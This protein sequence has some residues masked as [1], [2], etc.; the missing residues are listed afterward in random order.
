MQW[1]ANDKM[2][3]PKLDLISVPLFFS[4]KITKRFQGLDPH[5]YFTLYGMKTRRGT[6]SKRGK[7]I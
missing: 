2:Q 5:E 6:I 3:C 4:L 7:N 1:F